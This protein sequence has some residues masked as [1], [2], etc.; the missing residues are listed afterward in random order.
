[1]TQR[2]NL[3]VEVE[4]L[5]QEQFDQVIDSCHGVYGV[6]ISTV[7]GHEVIKKFKQDMP[8][9]KMSAMTSSL[10]AL[11]ET[12][13]REAGQQLCRFVIVE[14][15]DGYVLTL[16]V[17]QKLVLTTIAGTETNLG[18]LHSVSK[19]AAEAIGSRIKTT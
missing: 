19:S 10:L 7:D 18:M 16:R 2:I 15:S 3:P 11:G 4:N 5:C 6:L 13:A 14:N 12:I 9:S 1:M 8:A 17:G